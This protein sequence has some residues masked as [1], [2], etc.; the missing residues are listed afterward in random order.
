MDHNY[1]FQK[2]NGRSLCTRT[3]DHVEWGD[4]CAPHSPIS[5]PQR[6]FLILYNICPLRNFSG[7]RNEQRWC[8]SQ[9]KTNY[10]WHWALLGGPQQLSS[11][12]VVAAVILGVAGTFTHPYSTEGCLWRLVPDSIGVHSTFYR[13]DGIRDW[14]D[15][16][17]YRLEERWA[18]NAMVMTIHKMEL[19]YT[20]RAFPKWTVAWTV[21]LSAR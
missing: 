3:E 9:R 13:C 5:R 4:H 12:V 19:F 7:F 6:T 8:T 15:A 20:G 10:L 1:R 16:S 2:P 14:V 17:L 18:L 11:V 21:L